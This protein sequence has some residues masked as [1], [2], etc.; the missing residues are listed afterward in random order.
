MEMDTTP[1]YTLTSTNFSI[2]FFCAT[3]RRKVSFLLE[4]ETDWKEVMEILLACLETLPADT[5]RAARLATQRLE[6]W[7]L[8]QEGGQE[9]DLKIKTKFHKSEGHE[10]HKRV[11]LTFNDMFDTVITFSVRKR[12]LLQSLS[13]LAAGAVAPL[14][15][16]TEDIRRL[17][18]PRSLTTKLLAATTDSWRRRRRPAA[19]EP[20]RPPL[21]N[22]SAWG[23][24]P[25]CGKEGLKKVAQ[26]ISRSKSCAAKHLLQL[27]FGPEGNKGKPRS[28]P[29]AN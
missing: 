11:V 19:G 26:H 1:G 22:L 16:T 8:L 23:E 20:R 2:K 9:L 12:R 10:L 21:T 14:L 28:Q 24:C 17:E 29:G 7:A 6:A 15:R 13:D 27:S 3:Q 5:A 18:V 4:Y 25:Y